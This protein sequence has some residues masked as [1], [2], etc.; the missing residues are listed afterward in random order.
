MV[1]N[2]IYKKI[3]W[4]KE[5]MQKLICMIGLPRSGKST[6]CRDYYIGE[7]GYPVVCPDSI[8]LALYND[9]FIKSMEPYVWAITY[10]MIDSLFITGHP[11]V[12]LDSTNINEKLR[13]PIINRYSSKYEIDWNYMPTSK[14]ECMRRAIENKDY[15]IIPV[16]EK[17]YRT[18]DIQEIIDGTNCD[19][20]V[21]E[22]EQYL[23]EIQTEVD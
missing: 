14:Q 23:N 3:Q 21:V 20:Q 8:R 1:S 17:M 18:C 10:T 16:I 22:Y 4:S 2:R 5:I 9:R 12:V 6:F 7:K 19:T 13:R 11:V 15:Y